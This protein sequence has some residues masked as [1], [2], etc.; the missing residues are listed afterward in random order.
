MTQ[1]TTE[2][3]RTLIEKAAKKQQPHEEWLNSQHK[4][5]C[6]HNWRFTA[7]GH[8]SSFYVCENCLTEG[9]Y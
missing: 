1:P 9:E 5:G 3:L 6:D 7:H 8:N 4:N 2:E